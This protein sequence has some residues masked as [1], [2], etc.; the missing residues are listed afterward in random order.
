L[1]LLRDRCTHL[2]VYPNTVSQPLVL[3]SSHAPRTAFHLE[4]SFATDEKVD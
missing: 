2:H 4:M 3:T 1:L